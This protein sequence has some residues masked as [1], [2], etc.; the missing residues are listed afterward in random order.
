MLY[1]YCSN[2]CSSA[3]SRC[4]SMQIAL[5]TSA[6]TWTHVS[7]K[8]TAY[9]F[10]SSAQNRLQGLGCCRWKNFYFP[11]VSRKRSIILERQTPVDSLARTHFSHNCSLSLSVFIDFVTAC[12]YEEITLW[13]LNALRVGRLR[14]IGCW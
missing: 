8:T 7:C 1:M 9:L 12:L 14:L 2:Q 11:P 6:H 10:M 5:W 3:Y 4:Y 13:S